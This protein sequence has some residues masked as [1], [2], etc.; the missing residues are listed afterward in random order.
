MTVGGKDPQ[1]ALL[2]TSRHLSEDHVCAMNFLSVQQGEGW[3]PYLKG[4][5]Y[6]VQVE[7]PDQIRKLKL[8]ALQNYSQGHQGPKAGVE[9]RHSAFWFLIRVITGL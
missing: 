7:I 5:M 4:G 1:T 3:P 8:R 2:F 9:P 6:G